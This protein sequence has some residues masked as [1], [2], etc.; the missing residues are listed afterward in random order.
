MSRTGKIT[1]NFLSVRPQPPSSPF[2]RPLLSST[3]C[4]ENDLTSPA[5][6]NPRGLNFT[7]MPVMAEVRSPDVLHPQD[8]PCDCLTHGIQVKQGVVGS[9]KEK[10]ITGYCRP[11]TATALRS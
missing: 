10:R 1:S 5:T 2:K 4:Q 11:A 8:G 6:I 7:P 9:E 3:P